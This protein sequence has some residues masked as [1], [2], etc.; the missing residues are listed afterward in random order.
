MTT[1]TR[2]TRDYTL[3]FTDRLVCPQSIPVSTTRFLATDF[4]TGTIIVSLNYTLQISHIRSLHRRTL[5][6]NTFLHSLPYR[7]ELTTAWV[8][9][10]VF[11]ITPRHGLHRKQPRHYIVVEECLAGRCIGT[12]S[13]ETAYKTPFYYCVHVCYERY[14]ATCL[15][16]TIWNAYSYCLSCV[17]FVYSMNHSALLEVN[18]L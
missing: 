5:A 2:T 8:A 16:P 13:E 3:Q 15:Y 14:L 11:R 18:D 1:Y 12:V 4:N 9:Q 7:T 17:S 6:T 10:I